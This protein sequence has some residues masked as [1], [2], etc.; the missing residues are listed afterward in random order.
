MLTETEEAAFQAARS[1]G[2]VTT[3]SE[4]RRR[5]D[6]EQDSSEHETGGE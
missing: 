5:L 2:A 3:K 4:A 1:V 6:R